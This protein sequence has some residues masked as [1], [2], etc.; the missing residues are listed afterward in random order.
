VFSLG[1]GIDPSPLVD[2]ALLLAVSFAAG[3]IGAM[4]GVGGGL[5]LVPA[6]IL[7][8]GLEVHLAVAASL[9][10]VV[11]TTT[12]AASSRVGQGMV[13][14]R[15][16]MF[17]ETAT[18]LGGLAGALISVTVLASHDTILVF[19][20]I[21]VI[22]ASSVLMLAGRPRE[23]NRLRPPD[24]LA[25]RLGLGGEY[26]D[27]STGEWEEYRVHR[28]PTGLS[29]AGLAGLASGLFGIGGGIFKV[30]AMNAFMN[31]P[32]RIASATSTL[33]IGVTASAGAL[34][35]FFAGDVALLLVAPVALAVFAGSYASTHLGRTWPRE[36]LR[37]L[38]VGLLLVAAVLLFL[39]GIG[40][41]A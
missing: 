39:R 41:V 19:G 35:Y 13:N 17:L 31:V 15:L 1:D 14:L 24:P 22:V 6:L 32:F 36:R 11:A 30:P 27:P 38:F 23:A 28:V 4:M 2:L 7:L 12:G 9:V 29:F 26:V 40:V 37:Q 21:P 8:F 33:M 5:F 16:G 18:A 25:E 3:V 10:S 34:I 20:L